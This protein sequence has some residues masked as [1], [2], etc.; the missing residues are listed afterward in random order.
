MKVILETDRLIIRHPM[1]K[2]FYDVWIMKNSEAST[3]YTGGVIDIGYDDALK[4][5]NRQVEI[6]SERRNMVYTVALKESNKYIGYCGFKYC[7]ILQGIEFMYGYDDRYWGN[8][9]GLEAAT[10]IL[11]Y[12]VNELDLSIL[13]A[14]VNKSN[15]GSIKIIEK[16]GFEYIGDIEWPNQ[17][18]VNK[19]IFK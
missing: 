16:L 18:L 4:E 8:G 14:A 5:Y 13:A 12:G 2:D 1:L 17:E 3:L 15:I 9:Y 11:N 10:A 19:Y 7:D 6:F